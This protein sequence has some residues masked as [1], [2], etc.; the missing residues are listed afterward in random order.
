[1]QIVLLRTFLYVSLDAPVLSFLL[2]I[3]VVVELPSPQHAY[4]QLQ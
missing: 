1:M 3:N 2:S 4:S